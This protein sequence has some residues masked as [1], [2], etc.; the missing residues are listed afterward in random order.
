MNAQ[1]PFL[2]G[3]ATAGHQVEGNNVNA[4]IWLLEQVR[5][6]T[7]K[8]PSGDACDS[9]NRW[10]E[11]VA[12]IAGMGLN[13][14]RF[15]T[16]WSRIEPAPGR[17]SRASL[18]HYAAIAQRCRAQGV[19]P[20]VTLSHFTSPRWFAAQGGWENSEAPALFE[21]FAAQVAQALGD[22]VTHVVTFNEPNLPLMG[23]WTATPISDPVR[24]GLDAML[25]EAA[26]VSGSDRFSVWVYSR[27]EDVAL[28]HLLEGHHRARRAWKSVAP[29]ARIG[30]SLAVPD[31][32]AVSDDRGVE[33]Y[34]R[35]AET[36]FFEAVGE[37]DFVG[38]QTYGRLR[39]AADRVVGSDEA[40]ER[41]QSGDEYYPQAL[42]AAVRHAH[43]ATGRPVFVTENG[44]AASDD[45]QR[46]RYLSAALRSL[47]EARRGGTPVIG[48]LHWSLLDNFEWRRG[49]SQ[50]FGLVSVDRRTFRRT[51][52]ASAGVYADLVAARR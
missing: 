37:D 28:S 39:L 40:A 29:Q 38:V 42:G 3:A 25:A 24:D 23:R 7:F 30:L 16:E 5:G 10:E 27:G 31:V 1:A 51:P 15:S 33:A 36:P 47:D 44:L 2:W 11:D 21:R 13:A 43:A 34:R 8:E 14:Y 20:V 49:Y 4:D 9:L 19:A 22:S 35:F 12:L 17:F 52:K 41:T 48:Y 46:R 50:Q 18:N 32:Q 26:R 45:D 6:T